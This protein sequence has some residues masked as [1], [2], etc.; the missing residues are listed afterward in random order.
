MPLCEN[1][2]ELLLTGRDS[3]NNFI[4]RDACWHLLLGHFIT[5]ILQHNGVQKPLLQQPTDYCL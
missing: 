2:S 5:A 4:T 3:V 1:H